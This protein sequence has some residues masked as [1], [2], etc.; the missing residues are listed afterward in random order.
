MRKI[1]LAC[2]LFGAVVPAF[3]QSESHLQAAADLMAAMEVEDS[4][5]QMD[6]YMDAYMEQMA[7]SLNL[8]AA[9]RK[10]FDEGA[11]AALA[12]LKEEM[13]WENL[14]PEFSRLYASV[15]TE[16]ELREL[17]EFYRSPLGQ[18]FI[19]KMPELQQATMEWM[20]GFMGRFQQRINEMSAEMAQ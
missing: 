3:A 19:A 11:E 15:Y 7:G 18:K 8:D 10:K 9:A 17:A 12:I 20:T 6:D 2:A 13:S 14:E 5:D 16:A 4:L 1:L